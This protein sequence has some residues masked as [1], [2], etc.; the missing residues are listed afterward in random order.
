M[1][2]SVE[3]Y[4]FSSTFTLTF[5]NFQDNFLWSVNKIRD[6]CIGQNLTQYSTPRK[7]KAWSMSRCRLHDC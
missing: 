4:N 5:F 7:L 6:E 2:N 1:T 3:S